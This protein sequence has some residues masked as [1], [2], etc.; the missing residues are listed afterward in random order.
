MAAVASRLRLLAPD[1]PVV[2]IA[3]TNGKGTTL[4]A[5]EALL[6]ES[7]RRVGAFT[8]PHLLR[9]NERIRV[10]GEEVADDHITAAF[11]AIEEARGDI[12]LTYFEFATLAALVI[13][14][15]RAVDV[16]LLEV[17]LGGRLDA[18]NIL[19]PDIA[20][21]TGIALDHQQWLGDSLG[22]IAREKAG[23]LRRGR[24]VVVA[25]AN[26][27]QELLDRA[28]EL[29][30]GPVW[31]YGR[32]FGSSRRFRDSSTAAAVR[33]HVPEPVCCSSGCLPAGL[34]AGASPVPGSTVPP[35]RSGPPADGLCRWVEL[36]AGRC[37][38]SRVGLHAG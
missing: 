37:T 32:D 38:Q 1:C 30:A 33:S 26:P 15:E 9:F 21:V 35:C 13:F 11:A 36:P 12:S 27:P 5:L 34:A 6:L 10:A 31:G 7:G 24:P 28:A 20:V 22:Q 19:D 2:T 4:A 23:I 16:C 3:G 8:S 18:T 17:G 29:V 14:R 25:D